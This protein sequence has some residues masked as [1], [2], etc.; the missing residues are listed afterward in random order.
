MPKQSFK[1]ELIDSWDTES[2]AAISLKLK[3]RFS[4]TISFTLTMLTSVNIEYNGANLAAKRFLTMSLSR[5]LKWSIPGSFMT[6]CIFEIIHVKNLQSLT[7]RETFDNFV[8]ELMLN[9]REPLGI[10]EWS[11]NFIFQDEVVSKYYPINL[12]LEKYFVL[13][14]IPVSTEF[15]AA[16]VKGSDIFSWSCSFLY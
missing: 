5:F 16:N 8:S 4:V 14:R 10:R 15:H 11:K 7:E 3:W 2:S 9:R 1:M 6:E 12:L 13:L